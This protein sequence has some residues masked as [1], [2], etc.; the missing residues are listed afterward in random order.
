MSKGP[1][2]VMRMTVML[3]LVALL[4]GGVFGF[5]AVKNHFIAKYLAGMGNAS[6]TVATITAE[7]T[8]WQ[9]VLS[10]VGSLTAVNGA[11]LSAEISGIV[12]TI[13][14]E[15]GAD[16][17]T[18]AVLLT[19]RA[20]NDPAILAQLQAQAALDQINYDRDRKQFAADA[21]AQSQVDT[22]KANLDAARA[23][24]AGQQALIAEKTVRAPFAGR[25]GIRQV[26]IGQ[27]LAVGTQIVTLQQL[28][29]LYVDFY[30]PQQALSKIHVGQSVD[31]AIDAFPGQN[32]PATITSI[33]SVVDTA[34]RNIQIRATLKNDNL[35]LRPGMFATV[36]IGVDAP[37]SLITLPQTAIT[38]NP[39]GDT[40]YVVQH[41]NAAN[42]T[43]QLTAQQVFV[44]LG[45]TRGD[46]VSVL[47]GV[48]QGDEVVT[49]GQI[50]LRNGSVVTINN[51]VQ[52]TNDPNPNPPNE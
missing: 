20:N 12:D 34:T 2:P 32:F 22:D 25:L 1:R 3:I 30:L 13:H 48:K 10:S 47:T 40:V 42:G 51:S 24:V 31:T 38:Y 33:N 44:T 5:G 29:P 27:Y 4:F 23:Q 21:I 16:V 45:D 18:G 36:S 17:A 11:D 52:P 26:D 6:Q 43:A 49:A 41:G 15:S 39:Y 35:V 14:F 50:K 19:L 8:S 46:Q 28:N 7:N 37:Q 9:P